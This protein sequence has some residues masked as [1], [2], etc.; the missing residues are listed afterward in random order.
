[1]G[2]KQYFEENYDAEHLKKVVELNDVTSIEALMDEYAEW[3]SKN[4]HISDVMPSLLDLNF[5]ERR[6]KL[7]LNLRAVAL[8]TNISAA[9]I[10]RIECG[11]MESQYKLVKK[12]HDWYISNGA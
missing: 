10:S 6:Q 7:R 3:K 4:C 8:Q 1:M 9:T 2:A 12:L 11:Q 5:R